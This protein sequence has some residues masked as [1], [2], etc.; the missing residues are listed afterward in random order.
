MTFEPL[1]CIRYQICLSLLLFKIS[2]QAIVSEWGF[3]IG[4]MLCFRFFS[5][6]ISIRFIFLQYI[7]N[8][9]KDW[10]C[11]CYPFM[12][13]PNEGTS[14][15]VK[16]RLLIFS[17]FNAFCWVSTGKIVNIFNR[18][19]HYN[20]STLCSVIILTNICVHVYQRRLNSY[21]YYLKFK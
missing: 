8:P 9:C 20:M 16:P 1:P 11:A 18:K 17:V 10:S 13:P 14:S 2:K 5:L 7:C 4:Q 6:F 12:Y 21:M 15:N 3:N 19:N